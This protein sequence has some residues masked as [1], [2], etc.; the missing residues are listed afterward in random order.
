MNLFLGTDFIVFRKF[1]YAV[2]SFSLH[3]KNSLISL[4]LFVLTHFSFLR[5]LFNF[6]EFV[7]F[8]LFQLLIPS[9]N[10]CWP[11]RMGGVISI[12]IYLLRLALC[13]KYVANFRQ[14]SVR[15]REEDICVCVCVHALVFG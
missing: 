4:F 14:S 7:S 2:R 5:E 6:H 15:C 9:F 10:A 13:P 11:D 12:F 3:S 8:L 1:G